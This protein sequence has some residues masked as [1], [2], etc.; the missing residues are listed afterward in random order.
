MSKNDFECLASTGARLRQCFRILAP[1]SPMRG[2]RFRTRLSALNN[3]GADG[4]VCALCAIEYFQLLF[5]TVL[6]PRRFGTCVRTIEYTDT[7]GL[8]RC[9]ASFCRPSIVSRIAKP[10]ALCGSWGKMQDLSPLAPSAG[11][12][13]GWCFQPASKIPAPAQ[14][15]MQHSSS[16]RVARIGSVAP[17]RADDPRE[18]FR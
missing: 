2:S 12:P 6:E 14:A 13:R 18:R 3:P 11:R 8:W 4:T 7:G 1:S 10:L 17:N 16:G 9:V 15:L 5:G